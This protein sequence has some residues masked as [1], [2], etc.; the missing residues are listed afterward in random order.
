M[1][2]SGLSSHHVY[3]ILLLAT[4]AV[5]LNCPVSFG[6]MD[7]TLPN[8]QGGYKY[9]CRFNLK[10]YMTNGLEELTSQ[11]TSKLLPFE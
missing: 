9:S 3:H 2:C 7:Q 10:N 4:Y 6:K 8:F 5:S 11:L 1:M